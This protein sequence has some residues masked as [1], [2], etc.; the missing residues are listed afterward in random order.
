MASD[1]VNRVAS[2]M[3]S[4]TPGMGGVEHKRPEERT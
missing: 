3:R 2:D 1:T 4:G